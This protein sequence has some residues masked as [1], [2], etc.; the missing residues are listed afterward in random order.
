[1]TI[2]EYLRYARSI[3]SHDRTPAVYDNDLGE[4]IRQ[5]ELDKRK[6]DGCSWC[7]EFGSIPLRGFTPHGCVSTTV[8]YCPMCGKHLETKG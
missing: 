7:K 6:A 2:L 8:Q 3:Q 4:M 1:M 5:I